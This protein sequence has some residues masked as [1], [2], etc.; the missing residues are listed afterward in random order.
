MDKPQL[1]PEGKLKRFFVILGLLGL[2]PL[3]AVS[4]P[5]WGIDYYEHTIN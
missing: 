3:L 4:F 5:W 1:L 2:S